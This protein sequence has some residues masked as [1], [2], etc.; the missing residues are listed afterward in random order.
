MKN[1]IKTAMA[2]AMFA[3]TAAFAGAPPVTAPADGS[4]EIA[5]PTEA[6]AG[7]PK[8]IKPVLDNAHLKLAT[9]IL[10]KGALLAEHSSPMPVTIL[11]LKGSG[12]ATVGGKKL[13]IDVG[14]MVFVSPNVAH[15]VEPDA[16]TDLVLLVHHVK[17]AGANEGGPHHDDHG[18][19]QKP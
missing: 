7:A 3:S 2:T 12:N 6:G 17:V 5:L 16:G 15:A 19:A 8:D 11:V 10:R 18:A 14:H 4:V 13:R 9:I 1:T